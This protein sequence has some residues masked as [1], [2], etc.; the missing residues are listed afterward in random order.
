M[1]SYVEG[2]RWLVVQN[3]INFQEKDLNKGFKHKGFKVGGDKHKRV[4][5]KGLKLAVTNFT[6]IVMDILAF[7]RRIY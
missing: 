5:I 7:T 1:K 6:Q 3:Y 2:H 4:N